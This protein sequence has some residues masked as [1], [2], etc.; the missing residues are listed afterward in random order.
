LRR[1]GNGVMKDA[2]VPP[3]TPPWS[4]AAVVLSA[5]WHV[6]ERPRGKVY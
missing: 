4:P 2:I 5:K 1:S 6:T 3:G